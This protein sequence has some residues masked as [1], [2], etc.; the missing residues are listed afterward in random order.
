MLGFALVSSLVA[1]GAAGLVSHGIRRWNRRIQL[2]TATLDAAGSSARNAAAIPTR[3]HSRE[4]E[5][6]PE[7]VQR[8]FRAVLKEGQP[9]VAAA[10][11]SM[12]G[13]L[14]M[15][16]KGERWKSFLSRQRVVTRRSGFLWNACVTLRPGVKVHVLDSYIAG[17]GRMHASM[18]GLFSVAKVEGQGGIANAEL[19]RYFA[20]AV[21]YPTA[22]LPSQGVQWKAV[23]A[24]SATA[25]LVDGPLSLTLL[26]RFNEIGLVDSVHADAR[27]G[28]VDGKVVMMPW[29]C[30]VAQ[31]TMYDGMMVPGVGEAAWIRAH[32]RSPYFHGVLT[33]LIYEFVPQ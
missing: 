6:L 32:G 28:M 2:L 22:L 1:L 15:S 26:F 16:S 14:N 13:N 27:G 23:D 19:M 5:G 12:T 17:T 7:A 11:I 18:F 20:E 3:F 30:R 4:L 10:W 24:Q 9:I 21:W 8:Y 25:T 29:E 31:Y 33:S